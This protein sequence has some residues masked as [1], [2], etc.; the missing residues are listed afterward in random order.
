MIE[1]EEKADVNPVC[2]HCERELSKV[3]VQQLRS[4]LGV[5]YVYFCPSC[6]KVLGVTHRK[7]FWMG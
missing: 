1:V 5:R 4:F 2:A 6:R 3:W 7:G